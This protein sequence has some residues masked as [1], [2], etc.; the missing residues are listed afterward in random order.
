MDTT[1]QYGYAKINLHLDVTGRLENGFHA[2]NTVMQSLSLCDAVTLTR[3]DDCQYRLTCDN[4]LVPTD[5]SN[6]AIRAARAFEN[7]LGLKLGADIHIQK[8]IPMAAGL[9]GG[10]ADAAAVL[11]GL[12]ALCGD[13]L[14][15]SEL[16]AVGSALGADV[17]FC[18]AGGSAFAD[19]KGDILHPFPAMPDCTLVVA[20][21]GEGVSTPM[22][23]GL[24]D[25]LYRG[26]G[27]ESDYTP[28][29]VSALRQACELGDI[30]G[31]CEHTYNIFEAPILAARPVAA[32]I[33]HTLLDCGAIG[34]MMSG[35][36]PSVF[37][38]FDNGDAARIACERISAMGVTPHLCRPQR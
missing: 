36:G 1:L 18:I 38:I 5:E 8:N 26:F 27:S 16:C 30:R 21:G 17:P 15:L 29:D 6:L 31:I 3:R 32:Q 37:G 4:P 19:G 33:K 10:S 2:V 34:A 22:A 20:C 35:S 25:T 9:A 12:N 13:P 14:T 7:A 23:Y 28:R 24:L 11:K